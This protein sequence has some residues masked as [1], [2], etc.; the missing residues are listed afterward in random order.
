VIVVTR[1]V[2]FFAFHNLAFGNVNILT[3]ASIPE[4]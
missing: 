4:Y 2:Y 3:E 1:D